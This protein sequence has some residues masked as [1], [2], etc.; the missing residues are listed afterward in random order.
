[1]SSRLSRSDGTS[2][3]VPSNAERSQPRV[4]VAITR[5]SAL[6]ALLGYA[7]PGN[8]RELRETCEWIARTC[9]CRSVKRGCL[10]ARIL[11]AVP[12][13]RQ[14]LAR[15]DA[16]CLDER[17]ARFEA[18]IIAGALEAAGYNRSRAARLL[19]I[20]RSTLVDRIRRLGV[21]AEQEPVC[22]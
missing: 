16:P 2:I 11:A 3:A 13:R 6:D 20:K 10:P 22:A 18:E 15:S 14:E 12:D 8:V 5:A 9:R 1:M 19:G 21:G 4:P 17:V 7:W